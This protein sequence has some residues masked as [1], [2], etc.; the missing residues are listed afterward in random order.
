MSVSPQIA[1]E[2]WDAFL[3]GLEEALMRSVDVARV[4][5]AASATGRFMREG[6]G[7][8]GRNT[9][10]G[11][12]ALRKVSGR[13]ARSLT[14]AAESRTGGSREGFSRLKH[15]ARGFTSTFGSNVPYARI[16]ELGGTTKVTD[17][18]R[19]FFWYKFSETGD[20]KWKA[21]A[22]SD[23][24]TIPAR[25]Y[26]EPAVDDQKDYIDNYVSKAL[27]NLIKEVL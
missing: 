16:H 25:P 17:K 18:M 5:I 24:I 26:M 6:K 3:D 21:F 4:R 23:S 11:E 27:D 8:T 1:S 13:L 12:G 9:K 7:A 20:E 2:Q 22:L 15:T 10:T 14:G 19:G